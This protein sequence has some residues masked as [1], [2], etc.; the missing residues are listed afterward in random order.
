[1]TTSRPGTF[2]H[3]ATPNP[4]SPLNPQDQHGGESARV[5][6]RAG[7]SEMQK[8]DGVNIPGSWGRGGTSNRSSQ[9]GYGQVHGT[10][11]GGGGMNGDGF[12]VPSYLRQSRYIERLQAAQEAKITAQHEA[13][14]TQTKGHG[15]LS[16]RSST[17]SL[18]KLAPSHRGMTYEIIEHQPPEDTG[19]LTPLPSKWAETDKNQAMEVGPDGLDVRFIGTAKLHDHEAAAARTDNPMPVQGGLYYYEVTIASKGKDG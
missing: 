10:T 19:G 4:P 7:A 15:A 2:S 5:S 11:G 12:F 13:T 3:L 9:Y 6:Y 16:S 1:M 14:P 18:P 8:H 17:I